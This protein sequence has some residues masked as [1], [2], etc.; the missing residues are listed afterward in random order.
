VWLGGATA[1]K[2][3]PCWLLNAYFKAL[4]VKTRLLS[5][6]NG[7][8]FAVSTPQATWDCNVLGSGRAAG[9]VWTA[10]A[11]A[12]HLAKGWVPIMVGKMAYLPQ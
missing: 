5:L 11:P 2:I 7:L 10:Q 6:P 3:V 8:H 9:P 1:T 12:A 4:D